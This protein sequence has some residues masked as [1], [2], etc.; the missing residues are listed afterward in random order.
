ML[1]ARHA[2]CD[3]YLRSDLAFDSVS[4][5]IAEFMEELGNYVK[6]KAI[7]PAVMWD[8]QSWYVEHYYSMFKAGIEER[9]QIYHEELLYQNFQDLFDLLKQQSKKHRAPSADRGPEDLRRF[10]EDE[11]RVTSAFLQLQ[12]GGSVTP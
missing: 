8:A 10:A 1:R 7:P 3:R 12:A 4:D 9:R 11:L 2:V 5:Y 6:I